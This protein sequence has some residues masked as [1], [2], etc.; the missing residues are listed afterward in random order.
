MNSTG[1]LLVSGY[2]ESPYGA[3]PGVVRFALSDDGTVGEQLALSTGVVNPSFMALGGG[4]L[5]AVEELPD[6]RIAA[7]DAGTLELAGRLP[8]GGAD[9]A[10]LMLLGGDVWAANYS[11]GTASVTPLD[12]LLGSTTAVPPVLLSHPGSGPVAGRQDESHAHQVTATAWGTVLVSD[13]GADRVDEYSAESRV[14]LASAE[15]PP[16]TGPRHVA[17]KGGF[18][19]VAGELDGCVHVLIRSEADPVEG[20]GHVWRWLFKVPLA[21]AAGEIDA[22][23]DFAPSHIQLSG[24]GTKLYGAVRGPNT[25]VVLDVGGLVGATPAPPTFLRQVSCAG[26]WP[27]HFAVGRNRMYVANQRSNSV[28]VFDLDQDGL[29][30]AEPLQTLEFGSPTCLVLS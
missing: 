10:H 23:R 27:R 17:L 9:P 5:L 25:L 3:G 29:P 22:A 13:L 12:S 8:S 18:L 24:D 11:S 2:T 14:R 7:L 19:L 4:A 26:D 6:G 1:Q 21:A 20:A 15:L 28:T 30:L 16:G